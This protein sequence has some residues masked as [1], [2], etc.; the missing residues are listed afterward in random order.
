M[1]LKGRKRA[2]DMAQVVEP[3]QGSELKPQNQQNGKYI[4][5]YKEKIKTRHV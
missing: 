5:K 3:E 4:N 1:S 2:G